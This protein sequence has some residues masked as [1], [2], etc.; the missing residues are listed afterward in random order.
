MNQPGNGTDTRPPESPSGPLGLM[1]FDSSDKF[2]WTFP[3]GLPTFCSQGHVF[4]G[5]NPPSKPSR[6]GRKKCLDGCYRLCRRQITVFSAVSGPQALRATMSSTAQPSEHLLGCICHLEMRK[7]WW[8]Q[9][10]SSSHCSAAT[11]RSSPHSPN[12][13]VFS[14]TFRPFSEPRH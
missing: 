12:N 5:T 10:F 1:A 9:D 3:R 14:C 2:N 7:S 13:Q 8:F 6:P 4:Q 11:I